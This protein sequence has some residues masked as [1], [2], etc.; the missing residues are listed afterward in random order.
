MAQQQQFT[1]RDFGGLVEPDDPSTIQQNEFI[2]MDNL[3]NTTLLDTTYPDTLFMRAPTMTNLHDS[4]ANSICVGL[5]QFLPITNDHRA[6]LPVTLPFTLGSVSYRTNY[7]IVSV[8]VNAARDSIA[9]YAVDSD[10]GSWTDISPTAGT[11]T[12]YTHIDFTEYNR[13]MYATNLKRL[14]KWNGELTSKVWSIHDKGGTATT[15]T[16]TLTFTQNSDIVSGSGTTFDTELEAGALIRRESS[17]TYYEVESVDSATQVTLTSAFSETSGAGVADESEQAPVLGDNIGWY[18]NV[19]KDRLLSW[20]GGNWRS[21]FAASVTGDFEDW[22]SYGAYSTE[23]DQGNGQVA[24]G[25]G[26][27]DDFVILF[28][29]RSYYVYRYNSNDPA[30]PYVFIKKVDYGCIS[31]N[32]IVS[33][34]NRGVAY[35]TGYELRITNGV[36]DISLSNLRKKFARYF[37]D[38]SPAGYFYQ[39]AS[40]D[41]GYPSAAIDERRNLYCLCVGSDSSNPGNRVFFYDYAKNKWIG[42]YFDTNKLSN[43]MFLKRQQDNYIIGAPVSGNFQLKYFDWS[44][45]DSGG[46][47]IT[48]DTP[49]WD[50]GYPNKQKKV[51]FVDI[52]F[53]TTTT[54]TTFTLKG[55]FDLSLDSTGPTYDIAA[56]DSG[57]IKARFNLN[58][59]ACE[60]FGFQLA[61]THTSATQLGIV[62]ITV[63]FDLI[64]T[65]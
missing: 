4:I 33:I 58:G 2:K 57:R 11:G 21:T 5:H 13:R 38:Q 26:I 39:E 1:I 9:W 55:R 3:I 14:L 17:G 56:T 50:F 63:T 7:Y 53:Y 36:S 29:E 65:P 15:L 28:K 18:V 54:V 8:V 44:S 23:V 51:Y 30:V 10:T 40:T 42:N 61:E 25:V 20:G 52:E 43:I 22:S 19:H 47:G 49:N 46:T 62:S 60:R 59:R 64:D 45:V 24:A 41:V 48:L 34:P 16:G 32:T 31:H 35:F 12:A 6:V 27:W 37:D